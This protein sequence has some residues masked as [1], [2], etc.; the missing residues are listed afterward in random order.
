MSS[1]GEMKTR[2]HRHTRKAV[3][4]TAGTVVDTAA[5]AGRPRVSD[6]TRAEQLRAAKRAQREREREAGLVLARLRLPAALA[7]R[8]VFSARQP[9]F[10]DALAEFLDADTVEVAR[11]PQLNLLCWNRRSPLV[12]AKDAWSLYERNWRFIDSSQLGPAE[13][14][15]L[16]RLALRFGEGVTRG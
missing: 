4:T 6:L 15:L 2:P 1:L 7:A 3:S 8:L 16:D 5:P 10:A 9:G 13:R 12:S 14:G 11:Y